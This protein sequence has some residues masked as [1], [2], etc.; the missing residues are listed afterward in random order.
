ML[1]NNGLVLLAKNLLLKHW[2]IIF[3][4][5]LGLTPILWFKSGFIIAKGDNF[6]FFEPL[7]NFHRFSYVW[8]DYF[9][10][11]S[12]PQPGNPSPA[13]MIWMGVWVVLSGVGLSLDSIQALLQVFYFLGAG[14]S[15]YFLAS[16]IYKKEKITPLIASVFYM[17]NFFMILRT[18]ND[19]VSWVLV[20]LPLLITF[21][22]KVIRNV[23]NGQRLVGNALGFV[24]VSSILTSFITVNP[25]LLA[26]VG[27]V[28]VTL[29]IYTLISQVGIRLK[30]IKTLIFLSVVCILV[31]LWWIIPFSAQVIPF[32]Q[33]SSSLGTPTTIDSWSFV[34]ARASFLNLF[35]LNGL[36]AWGSEYFPYAESYAN[37]LLILLAFVPMLLAFSG[38]LFKSKYLRINLLFSVSVLAL[39]FLSK[40]IHP[41]FESV[42]L[43]FY[44]YIPGFFL[45]R[46]PFPKFFI[47]LLIPL[48]L[49]IGSSV[50]SIAA[51]LRKVRIFHGRVVSGVFVGLIICSFLISA[52]PLVTGDVIL[53]KTESLPFDSYVKIPAYWY[54][55]SDYINA[56]KGDFRIL[57]IPSDDYYQM[58]YTWGYY[59]ADAFP[60][61]LIVKPVIQQLSGGYTTNEELTSLVYSKIA[62]NETAGFVSL[63][64]LLN[65]KYLLQRN[66]VSWNLT[67]RT[68][69]SPETVKSFL[70]SVPGVNLERFL[71]GT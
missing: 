16:T 29:F 56:Q 40:G 47:L 24:A 26:L 31:N 41:P 36:W 4:I 25:P 48:A 27:L 45:F 14:L 52:F 19:G 34:H 44:E 38:L 7:L 63:L 69:L 21:Y 10:V 61:R 1:K 3:L 2:K 23:R 28:L 59:G 71:W 49:L 35:Q 54:D 33:G 17:F 18:L 39:L 30:I 6:P 53:G 13:G 8:Q 5:I 42:N 55:A 12:I 62:L 20:F 11:G 51:R 57:L 70:G 65:V 43:F 64:S 50:N 9:N 67:D 68:I 15:M 46:E 60:S 22:I 66:D 37:P 32:I 58:P